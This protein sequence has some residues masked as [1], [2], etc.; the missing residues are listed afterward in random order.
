MFRPVAPRRGGAGRCWGC[1]RRRGA[2]ESRGQKARRAEPCMD[3]PRR[4]GCADGSGQGQGVLR[5]CPEE[6]ERQCW[7]WALQPVGYAA[8]CGC[9]CAGSAETVGEESRSLGTCAM[10]S[11][12]LRRGAQRGLPTLFG[13]LSSVQGAGGMDGAGS[14]RGM[15]LWED[16][17]LTWERRQC[18]PLLDSRQQGFL[19]FGAAKCSGGSSCAWGEMCWEFTQTL[20]RSMG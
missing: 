10:R 7:P 14:Q 3:T 18:T 4:S 9:V 20:T 13:L 1:L 12:L 6:P 17:Q 16:L 8:G 5:D 19:D 11:A 15:W 2:W